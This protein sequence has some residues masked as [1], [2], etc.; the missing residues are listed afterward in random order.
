[1]TGVEAAGGPAENEDRLGEADLSCEIRRYREAAG[2][3]QAELANLVGYSREYVSRAERPSKGMASAA[4]VEAIDRVLRAGGELVALRTAVQGERLARR[5]PDRADSGELCES[6]ERV[7]AVD[8]ELEELRRDLGGVLGGGRR[9]DHVEADLWDR[10][11]AQHGVSAKDR[12]A[13]DL[14]DDRFREA[15]V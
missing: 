5:V 6:R 11:V 2:L 3:S 14:L 15:V 1:V 12:S 4:L 8:G 10:V 9:L 13:G 7:S